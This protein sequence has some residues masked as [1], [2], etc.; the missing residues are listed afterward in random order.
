MGG[1][2]P[3]PTYFWPWT[4]ES[5][6]SQT[7]TDT[8]TLDALSQTSDLFYPI[9]GGGYAESGVSSFPGPFADVSQSSHHYVLDLSFKYAAVPEPATWTLAMFG[10]FLTGAAL[11]RRALRDSAADLPLRNTV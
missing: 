1:S 10:F 7:V 6:H 11:R 3:G 9:S 4:L 2:E 5:I 8:A